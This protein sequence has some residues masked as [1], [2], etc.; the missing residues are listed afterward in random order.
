[1]G[2]AVGRLNG[3]KDESIH[4]LD[5]IKGKGGKQP[6]HITLLSGGT[7]TSHNRWRHSL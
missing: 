5:A 3:W 1:M 4:K 2:I 7:V 6:F